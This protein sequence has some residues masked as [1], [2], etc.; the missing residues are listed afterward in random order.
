[1]TWNFACKHCECIYIYIYIYTHIKKEIEKH[2]HKWS[3]RVGKS[4]HEAK[5]NFLLA[6]TF[7]D[8]LH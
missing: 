3:H 7:Y 5:R 2:K 4:S 6:L 8:H 1:M